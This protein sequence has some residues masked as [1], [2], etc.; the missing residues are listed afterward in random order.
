[1]RSRCGCGLSRAGLEH[2][3]AAGLLRLWQERLR[4][5]EVRAGAHQRSRI[6]LDPASQPGPHETHPE[7]IPT[8]DDQAAAPVAYR[9][10]P[11]ALDT[12]S[13]TAYRPPNIRATAIVNESAR[14][15]IVPITV[16]PAVS[17]STWLRRPRGRCREEPAARNAHAWPAAW[18]S[19]PTRAGYRVGTKESTSAYS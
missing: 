9:L 2:S 14:P 6:I 10:E 13:K 19:S 3:P 7:P 11:D 1:M 18:F 4:F 15:N 5:Q 16:T 12:I 8:K 17:P